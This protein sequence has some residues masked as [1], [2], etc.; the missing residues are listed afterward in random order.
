[1]GSSPNPR[2]PS[3]KSHLLLPLGWRT[4]PGAQ[5]QDAQVSGM[6]EILPP[7]PA[8]KA[9]PQ[10]S[11][12]PREDTEL[13]ETTLVQPFEPEAG[14]V[15]LATLEQALPT[16]SDTQSPVAVSADVSTDGAAGVAAEV[17]ADVVADVAAHVSAFQYIVFSAVVQLGAPECY[18]P[19]PEV[20]I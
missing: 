3:I 17:A 4:T 7:R 1:M 5:V 2:E 13:L 8:S 6:Q 20:D 18:F 9:E 19:L 16:S 15:Q 12:L 14:P 11:L 10:E